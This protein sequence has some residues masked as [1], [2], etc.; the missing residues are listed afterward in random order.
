M[1]TYLDDVLIQDTTTDTM[2]QTLTQYH[3]ILKNENL[4]AAPDKSVF[5][6]DSVIFLGQQFQN[7]HIHPLKS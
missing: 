7:N 3:T 6:F 1:I 5:F 2:L 4:K